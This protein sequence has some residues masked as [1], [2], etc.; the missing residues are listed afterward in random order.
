MTKIKRVKN[1]DDIDSMSLN[2][3]QQL[4]YNNFDKWEFVVLLS[5]AALNHLVCFLVLTVDI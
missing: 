1:G 2:H 5:L 3:S 4:Q